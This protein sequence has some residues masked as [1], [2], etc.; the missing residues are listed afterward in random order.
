MHLTTLTFF[1]T[2]RVR[3]ELQFHTPIAEPLKLLL[4]DV[5]VTLLTNLFL[6]AMG[7][8]GGW[9]LARILQPAGRWGACC[10]GPLAFAAYSSFSLW[11]SSA[12]TDY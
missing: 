5:P 2:F 7:L 8:I 12:V 10:S 3:K 6:A 4:N 9:L 1:E 11:T